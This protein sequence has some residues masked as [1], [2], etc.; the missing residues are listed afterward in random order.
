M[1]I[2]IY[3]CMYYAVAYTYAHTRYM[4]THKTHF[5][6]QILSRTLCMYV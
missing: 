5:C 6:T 3:I 1:H 2:Y 4:L